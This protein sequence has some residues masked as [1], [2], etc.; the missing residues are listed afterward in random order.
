MGTQ[1]DMNKFNTMISQAS[2]SIL[3]NSDC[4]K[5]RQVEKLKQNFLNAETNLAS[6][7]NQVQV[8]EKNYV[9]F[10]QGSVAYNELLDNQLHKK[11]EIIA[12]KFTEKFNEE[13]T[14]IKSQINTYSGL[15]INFKNIFDLFIKYKKENVLLFKKLKEGTNDV[16]TNERKTYYEDQNI[17]RLKLFYF[18]FLLVVY[19]IFV[20]CF[21]SFSLIYPSQSN[22]MVRLVIF[23]ALIALPFVST[24]ILGIIIYLIY[25][26]YNLLPK[27]VYGEKNY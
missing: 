21:A 6:A 15:L 2:D 19:I 17:D 3:C 26:G 5:Q 27:N 7:S 24:W 20:I 18:Y 10:T 4:K 9:T 22:W 11:A 16:L 14:K 13:N 23:I 1:F 12:E 8:A 25:E